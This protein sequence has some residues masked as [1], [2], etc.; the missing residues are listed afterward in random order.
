MNSNFANIDGSILKLKLDNGKFIEE[1]DLYYFSLCSEKLFNHPH[2]FN[3]YRVLSTFFNQWKE[4]VLALTKSNKIIFLPFDFSD[5]YLGCLRLKV[6]PNDNIEIVY[7]YTEKVMGYE[8][9]PDDIINLSIE[10]MIDDFEQTS[11]KFYYSKPDF[12]ALCEDIIS[13]LEKM[14]QKS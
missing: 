9:S 7:G 2:Q 14:Y 11:H 1:T 6:I 12:I 4:K 3:I 8:V 5:E 10:T 13:N